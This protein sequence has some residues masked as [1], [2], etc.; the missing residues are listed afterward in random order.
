MSTTNT[1]RQHGFTIIELMIVIAIIG[2]L[3]ATV[4]PIFVGGNIEQRRADAVRTAETFGFS[5]VTITES[6]RW[7][8][9][10]GCGADDKFA[11]QANATNS[12]DKKVSIVICCGRGSKGCTVRVR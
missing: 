8:G 2:I 9:W 7:A 3:V 12:L 6:S 5:G 4:I 1:T 11:F 10:N